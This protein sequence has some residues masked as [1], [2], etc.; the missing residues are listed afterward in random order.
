MPSV[1][2][3]NWKYQ[4]LELNIGVVKSACN[5]NDIFLNGDDLVYNWN[6]S[7]GY[8]FE[9]VG[10]VNVGNKVGFT[11][12]FKQVHKPVILRLRTTPADIS[13]N[14]SS[15]EDWRNTDKIEFPLDAEQTKET[16]PDETIEQQWDYLHRLKARSRQ[17]DLQISRK[18]G[19]PEKAAAGLPEHTVELGEL[20]KYWLQI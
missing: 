16:Q 14:I 10:D 8:G 9:S 19:K 1:A 18:S 4:P 3:V 13:S 7:F 15:A 6:G 2:S 5:G 17:L 20:Q 12:S 11:A